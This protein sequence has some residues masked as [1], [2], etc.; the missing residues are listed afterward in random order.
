MKKPLFLLTVI[1][2]LCYWRPLISWSFFGISRTPE[3]SQQV[4][5]QEE[6]IQE[7]EQDQDTEEPAGLYKPVTLLLDPAGD[8]KTT[9]RTIDDSFERSITLQCAEQI[10]ARIAAQYTGRNVKVMLTRLPGDILEPLQT[11]QFANRIPVDFYVSLHFYASN[12][13]PHPVYFYY[14]TYTPAL[15]T[16]IKHAQELAFYPY[17]QAYLLHKT[18]TQKYAHMC[19]QTVEK[20]QKAHGLLCHPSRGLPFKPLLGVTVPALACEM[21]LHKKDD[22]KKLVGPLTDALINIIDQLQTTSALS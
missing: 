5:K 22:W 18:D 3:Q 15:D 17:Y 9:G 13:V 12:Q 6:Q 20:V 14:F 2:I 16:G 8:A 4:I 1:L 7:Q 11:A 21:G 19:V 10:K